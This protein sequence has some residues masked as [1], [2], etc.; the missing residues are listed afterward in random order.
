MFFLQMS[1][2]PGSGKSTLSR[3][4]AERTGAIVLDHD[5]V[6]TALLEASEELLDPKETGNISY[7]ID[8]AL[9]DF[10]LSQGRSVILDSPCMYEVM[11]A[12]GGALAEKHGA[13]YK[14]IECFLGDV[15][16]LDR[17]LTARPRLRSQVAGVPAKMKEGFVLTQETSKSKR[18]SDVP[19]LIVDTGQPLDRYIT[20]ALAFLAEEKDGSDYSNQLS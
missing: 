11:L 2:Y 3:I 10:L 12:K 6:K 18:P 5:I 19:Y 8:W 7:H 16:E 4:L 20:E 15:E 17:R 1:G 13:A 14:Y 9:A